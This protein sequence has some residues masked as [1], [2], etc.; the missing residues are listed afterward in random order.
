[1]LRLN[2]TLAGRANTPASTA[3]QP[4]G[5]LPPYAKPQAPRRRNKRGCKPGHPS[6]ARLRPEQ[7]DHRQT[8]RLPDC[9]DCG[10]ELAR[11][12]RTRTRI[13]EDLPDNLKSEVTEHTIHR[14][15]CPCCK[16]QV[17]PKVPDALPGC[18]LGHRLVTLSAW[19]HYGLGDTTRQI[20]DVLD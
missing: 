7:I 6:V 5:V 17:E 12:G 18:T 11:T 9:P 16:K 4:S 10:G 2:V 20:V 13:V 15:W 3:H 14:D 19:L 8:H 1:M